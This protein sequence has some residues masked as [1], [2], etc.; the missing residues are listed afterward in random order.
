[1][2][3]AIVVVLTSVLSWA[4]IRLI[5]KKEIHSFVKNLHTQSEMHETM[6]HFFDLGNDDDEFDDD[7]PSQLT[8][9]QRKDMIKVIIM[10]DQAYWVS[11]N[12]FY[13]SDAIDGRPEPG[14]A[15]PIDTTTMSKKDV[16][17]M[18][19]ILD[20]LQNGSNNDSSSAGDD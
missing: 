8:K 9:L 10:D 7:L 5:N 13:V 14:T 1:M 19:S 16:D 18:L 20:S 2:I 17:K 3:Y 15:Q 12:I 4:I 11:E 6:K